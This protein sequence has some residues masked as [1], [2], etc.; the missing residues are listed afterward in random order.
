MAYNKYFIYH[1]FTINICF[2]SWLL[3][4]DVEHLSL[5][6][7]F[8]QDQSILVPNEIWVFGVEA[9]SLHASLKQANDVAIVRVLSEGQA[10]A[11]MHEFLEFFWLILAKLL[12][13]GLLFLLL[14][15][16]VLLGF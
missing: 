9:V 12:D 1:S 3:V 16:G 15:V 14:D 4:D 6:G 7:L 11:V 10:S 2:L 5:Y 13:F 8:F